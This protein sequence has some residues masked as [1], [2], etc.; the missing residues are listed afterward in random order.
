MTVFSSLG[1]LLLSALIFSSLS[2]TFNKHIRRQMLK[3]YSKDNLPPQDVCPGTRAAPVMWKRKRKTI[4]TSTGFP[5]V[6]LMA[7]TAFLISNHVW[8][9]SVMEGSRRTSGG[10]FCTF[11]YYVCPVRFSNWLSSV[12]WGLTSA[13]PSDI[14]TSQVPQVAYFLFFQYLWQC[15]FLDFLMLRNSLKR[16]PIM[17]LQCPGW[18]SIRL[19]PRGSLTIDC[20]RSGGPPNIKERGQTSDFLTFDQQKE[21]ISSSNWIL[22][23]DMSSQ[24]TNHV[25]AQSCS[26][27]P[28]C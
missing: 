28:A 12:G 22:I 15:H 24:G 25:K 16:L 6:Q 2:T 3:I 13:S 7:G 23:Q 4:L 20:W 19:V 18:L 10:I 11:E 5:P 14:P 27:Q 26:H 1:L 9:F 8:V 17:A 21:N